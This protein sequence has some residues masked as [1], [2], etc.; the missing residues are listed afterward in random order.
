MSVNLQCAN[1][2]IIAESWWNSS[3]ECQAIGRV[4]RALQPKVC[5]AVKIMARDCIDLYVHKMQWKK[6]QQIKRVVKG[7]NPRVGLPDDIDI[8]VGKSNSWDWVGAFGPIERHNG[9]LRVRSPSDE[10]TEEA[11]NHDESA[12]DDD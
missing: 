3:L 2:V 11:P 4:H 8:K 10:R 7:W 6:Y 12:E 1:R 9:H 5:Y